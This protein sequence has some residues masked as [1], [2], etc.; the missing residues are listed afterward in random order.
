MVVDHFPLKRTT[1]QGDKE[2]IRTREKILTD[3]HLTRYLLIIV[4]SMNGFD[5]LTTKCLKII[6]F[7]GTGITTYVEQLTCSAMQYV[8]LPS[9]S[10]QLAMLFFLRA[11]RITL[12]GVCF[13]ANYTKEGDSIFNDNFGS[14]DFYSVE[15]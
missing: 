11:L 12:Q 14:I 6:K 1:D 8:C 9:S 5:R 3:L 7:G 4:F 15:I 2:R 10:M 13:Y